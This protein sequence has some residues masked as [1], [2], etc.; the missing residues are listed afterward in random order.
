MFEQYSIPSMAFCVDSV[1]SFYHNNLPPWDSAFSADGLVV[2]FNTASTSVIPIL[3]GKGI[4]SHAKR[5]HGFLFFKLLGLIIFISIPWGSSQATEYL[6]KLIQLKYPNFPTRVT[7]P[8]CSV[9]FPLSYLHFSHI[10]D[11]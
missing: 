5:Y 11:H 7:T 6:L 10:C 4:M 8:Q 9:C 3:S 2:S 1:M